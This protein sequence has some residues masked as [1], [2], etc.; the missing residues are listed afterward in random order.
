MNMIKYLLL[1][2]AFVASL[3]SCS[4]KK[5]PAGDLPVIN[6]SD[7]VEEV[8]SLPLSD[9]AAQVE[10]VPLE[11]TDSSLIAEVSNVQVTEHDIWVK[12]SKSQSV[13][14]F[15]REG[16]F[17][18]KVGRV[19]QG[20][21]EY[22][23]LGGFMVDE[24]R[25]EVYL[26]TVSNGVYA[27]DFNGAFKWTIASTQTINTHFK[28]GLGIGYTRFQGHFLATASSPIITP[29]SKDS[30]W[31]LAALDSCFQ[32][33]KMFRNPAYEGHEDFILKQRE[34]GMS[35]YWVETSPSIDTYNGRMTV[36]FDDT[37][38]LYMYDAEHETLSPQ[39]TL[40]S[41]ED[42]GDYEQTHQWLKTRKAFDGLYLTAHYDTKDYIYLI[43]RKG[44][45][46]RIYCYDKQNGKVRLLKGEG[47]IT[48]RPITS[49]AVFRRFEGKYRLT[50]D[51]CG[52]N[53]QL[54]YRSGGKYWVNVFTSEDEI[55]V[56]MLRTVEVKDAP[57]RDRFVKELE[58]LR[59]NEDSNPLLMIVPLK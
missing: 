3:T 25:Q 31:A 33:R 16:K 13:F 8:T 7:N 34:S 14:R 29:C 5:V 45:E 6:L 42:K 17:L 36:K 19:G 18:N 30:L 47:Q 50:N 1:L 55:D 48:E 11:L 32:I 27:Y 37:D 46:T 56:D 12:S 58:N 9:A 49:K 2:V 21:G 26:T 41:R 28:R 20:P 10:I 38:I 52:G 15:S 23:Y 53:F 22:S 44:E 35:S 51:L 4:E 40:F 59:D 54:N 24:D 39:Y 43:G 57:M